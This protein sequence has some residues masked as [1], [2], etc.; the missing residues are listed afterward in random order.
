MNAIKKLFCTGALL[1]CIFGVAFAVSV[2]ANNDKTPEIF[3]Q[4]VMYDDKFSILYAVDADSISG[5]SLTITVT[6]DNGGTWSKTMPATENNQLTVKDRAA[7]VFITPGIGPSDFTTNYYV[8]VSSNDVESN[9]KR[10]SVAE[11]LN[12]RLYKNGIASATEGADLTRKEF[13]LSTLEFGAN[14]ERVLYNLD[15]DPNNDRKHLV[16]DYKY[17]YTDLGTID[18]NF[19]AGV[20]APGTTLKFTPSDATKKYQS[21]EIDEKGS[22]DETAGKDIAN[23]GSITADS[24]TVIME[25]PSYKPGN[26]KFYNMSKNITTAGTKRIADFNATTTPL[27]TYPAANQNKISSAVV[28]KISQHSLLTNYESFIRVDNTNTNGLESSDYITVSEFDMKFSNFKIPSTDKDLKNYFLNI[29]LYD[30]KDEGA[31]YIYMVK[32]DDGTLSLGEKNTAKIVA[33]E[34]FN[35]RLEV[36]FNTTENTASVDVY[37]NNVYAT[38]KEFTGF[39]KGCRKTWITL[40]SAQYNSAEGAT[41]GT[42]YIDNMFF[43]MIEPEYKTTN[44]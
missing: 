36:V 15:T 5:D 3:S 34:W 29:R 37:I 30:G 22:I 13:Y 23:G 21:F 26:G 40:K 14:A 2:S 43:G 8:T 7:Y 28:N 19:S 20:Y 39:E 35:V 4:N 41:Q 11:Y 17:I 27:V 33:D 32:N 12:E 6:S 42:V 44:N 18:G 38:T 31:H 24:N 10:Y 1:T 25:K 9:V 16:T